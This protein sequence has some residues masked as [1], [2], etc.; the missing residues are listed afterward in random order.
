VNHAYYQFV[1]LRWDDLDVALLPAQHHELVRVINIKR[2]EALAGIAD[3]LAR[4]LDASLLVMRQEAN[5]ATLSLAAET[6][7]EQAGDSPC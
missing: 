6:A 4:L 5:A 2:H 3:P 1:T 7:S